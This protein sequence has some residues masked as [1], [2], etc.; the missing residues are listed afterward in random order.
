MK[1]NI[2]DDKDIYCKLPNGR[3]KKIGYKWEGFPADG[4]WL[5]QNGRTSARCLIGID[6]K[7][8][9]FALQY[10]QHEQGIVDAVQNRENKKGLVSLYDIARLACDYFAHVAAAQ[11][12]RGSEE[13]QG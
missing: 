10:R 13:A 5:V 8:P 9:I 6:E 11:I 7:V 3:Y 2:Y 4:I 12:E 1:K